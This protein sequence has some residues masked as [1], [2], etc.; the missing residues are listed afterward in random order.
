VLLNTAAALIVAGKA[1]SLED[2][3]AR[4]A[5][6]IDS[7]AAGLALDKLVAVTHDAS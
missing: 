3:V 6:A 5:A 4:A 2:G 7:G 1:T